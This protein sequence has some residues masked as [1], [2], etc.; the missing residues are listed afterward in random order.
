MSPDRDRFRW[1]FE[2]G[3]GDRMHG[4]VHR[5]LKPSRPLPDWDKVYCAAYEAA[6]VTPGLSLEAAWAQFEKDRRS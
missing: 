6:F 3:K 2:A 1:G 5:N 4:A